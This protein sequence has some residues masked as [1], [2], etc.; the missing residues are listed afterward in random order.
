LQKPRPNLNPRTVERRAI[1]RGTRGRGEED[2]LMVMVG[3][4]EEEGKGDRI[5]C[6]EEEEERGAEGR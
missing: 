4:G 3:E 1:T 6:F 2:S 5:A